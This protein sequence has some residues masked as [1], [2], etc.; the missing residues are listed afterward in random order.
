MHLF[1]VGYVSMPLLRMKQVHDGGLS[2]ADNFSIASRML[3]ATLHAL[4]C[5]QSMIMSIQLVS[6]RLRPSLSSHKPNFFF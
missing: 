2:P 5:A 3:L 4:I 6:A 1:L